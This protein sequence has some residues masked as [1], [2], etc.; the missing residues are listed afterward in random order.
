MLLTNKLI[1][2]YV[3]FVILVYINIKSIKNKK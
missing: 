2:E 1:D 3:L